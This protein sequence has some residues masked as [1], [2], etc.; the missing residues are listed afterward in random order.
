MARLSSVKRSVLPASVVN[1][2]RLQRSPMQSSTSRI[3]H[4]Q[5]SS[6]RFTGGGIFGAVFMVGIG[7]GRVT[8]LL[9]APLLWAILVFGML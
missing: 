9:P 5:A 2:S 3:G 1:V 8:G 7:Y 4:R 6:S